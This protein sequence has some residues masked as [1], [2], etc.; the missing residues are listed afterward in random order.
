MGP[1]PKEKLHQR[2]QMEIDGLHGDLIVENSRRIFIGKP[3]EEL[4]PKPPSLTYK[5]D[6]SRAEVR[7]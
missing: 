5:P 6:T 4:K 3:T 7:P 2:R 1:E